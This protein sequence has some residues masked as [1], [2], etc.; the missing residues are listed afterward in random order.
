MQSLIQVE[1]YKR[2]ELERDN[3]LASQQRQSENA[4]ELQ[5]QEKIQ[6]TLRPEPLNGAATTKKGIMPYSTVVW[7]ENMVTPSR[8][9]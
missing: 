5:R 4:M 3:F 2:A 1:R 7:A 8:C 6:K 9:L